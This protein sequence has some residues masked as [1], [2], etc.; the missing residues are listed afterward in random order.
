MESKEKVCSLLENPDLQF[1][2][3]EFLSC[4]KETISR[5][6]A[7]TLLQ[8]KSLDKIYDEKFGRPTISKEISNL[9]PSPPHPSQNSIFTKEEIAQHFQIMRDSI[10]GNVSKHDISLYCEVLDTV[11]FENGIK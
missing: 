6:T 1:K 9:P 10:C 7:L 11:L 5:G 4:L 3:R 8:Q 2:T